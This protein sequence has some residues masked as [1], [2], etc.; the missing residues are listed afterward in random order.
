MVVS[1]HRDLGQ[2]HSLLITDKSFED[3]ATFKYLATKVTKLYSRRIGKQ[4]KF[5][6]CLLPFCSETH[7]FSSPLQKLQD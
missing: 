6:K 2:N 1:R 3:A 7:V 5:G 4:I